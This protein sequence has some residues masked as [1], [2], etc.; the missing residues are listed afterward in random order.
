[1][2]GWARANILYDRYVGLPPMG[3]VQEAV[4]LFVWL[5]RQEAD[6]FK[7]KILAEGLSDIV[8]A[9]QGKTD[10]HNHF[11]AYVEAVFPFSATTRKVDQEKTNRQLEI[12]SKMGPIGMTPINTKGTLAK[13]MKTVQISQEDKIRLQKINRKGLTK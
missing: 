11:K 3:G 2:E 9:N 13:A 12:I 1:M 8:A 6:I 4:F 7:T 5:R 10:M